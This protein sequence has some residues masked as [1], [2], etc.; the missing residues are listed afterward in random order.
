MPTREDNE[1]LR[2]YTSAAG[3]G[4]YLRRAGSYGYCMLAD[5]G[6]V[7]VL[8]VRWVFPKLLCREDD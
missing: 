4:F 1:H 3:C 7:L 2:P 8:S 5:L 6:R